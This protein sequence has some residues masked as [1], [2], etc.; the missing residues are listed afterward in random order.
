VGPH[1]L[2]DIDGIRPAAGF[3][4]DFLE[5]VIQGK[6]SVWDDLFDRLLGAQIGLHKP[7]PSQLQSD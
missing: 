1:L 6:I 2:Y 7:D 4:D 5:P 3:L